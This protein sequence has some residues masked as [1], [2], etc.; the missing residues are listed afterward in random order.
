MNDKKTMIIVGAVIGVVLLL[1]LILFF[2]TRRNNAQPEEKITLVYWGLWEPESV[3]RPLIEKYESINTHVNIEYVQR[4]FTQYDSTLFTRISQG[5]TDN[6]PSPDIVRIGNSW[7]NK[8]QPYLSPLPSSVMSASEY[9]QSFYP[10]ALTDFTGTDGNIYAMPLEIDGLALFY[11]KKLFNDAGI[12][13]PPTDWDAFIEAAKKLTK[14]EGDR[15]V[16]AGAAMGNSQNIKHSADIYS[17][18]LLQNGVTIIDS[19]AKQVDFSSTRAQSALEFYTNF[20]SLHKTWSPDLA[21]DI[22]V[23][24][25]GK[26]GMMFAPSWRAFD[27]I[28]SA[29]EIEFGIAPAPQLPGNQPV[30]YAMYWGEAVT[31]T[32][33]NQLE[34]WKF[35]KFL[36][37]PEQQKAFFSNSSQIRA[38]GEPYSRVS[39][40]SELSSHQYASAF[41][42]MA[43]TMKA[44]RMPEQFLMEDSIRTAINDVAEGG[45]DI[46]TALREAQERI[47]EKLA[48]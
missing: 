38:F 19:T 46:S 33:S 24:Y 44:W 40:A 2:L 15:I 41:T 13:E 31:R 43:P 5:T 28:A 26:L 37:E 30:N 1:G 14:T 21:N 3:M 42:Q 29:P 45:V 18:L 47:N 9:S 39:L 22:E 11:N 6:T 7:L 48:Q 25:S 36:S 17:L 27:V 35:V 10:T 20:I 12:T 8:F 23:F 32:S 16:Q 4:P 34:A